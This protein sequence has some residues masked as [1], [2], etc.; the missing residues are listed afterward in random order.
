[1]DADLQ[2]D[3]GVPLAWY[4]V[5][6]EIAK[7]PDQAVRMSD[8]ADQVVLSRSWLTRRIAQLESAGLVERRAAAGDGRGV[9]AAM[10]DDGRER[11][12]AMEKSHARSIQRYFST[13]LDDDEAE[14]VARAFARIADAGAEHRANGDMAGR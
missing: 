13:H 7:A 8:L 2:A 3:C 12:A 14:V 4:D 10:T 9:V 1:M 11:F 6:I 5:L